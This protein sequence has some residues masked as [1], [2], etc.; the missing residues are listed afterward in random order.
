VL[1]W[2]N[3]PDQHHSKQSKHA[4][5]TRETFK[6]VYDQFAGAIRNYIYYRSG[7]TSLADDITQETFIRIWEKQIT[8]DEKKTRSLLYK[9]ANDFLIDH[10]RKHNIRIEYLSDLKFRLKADLEES[11][12]QEMMR[13]KCEKALSVLTEK[14]RI[15]FLMSKK[16][17]MKYSEIAECLNI[18]KKA[19]EKRM[20]QA[21]KKMKL[22]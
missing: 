7:N 1:I 3:F 17:E 15:V 9:I 5:L 16:D 6:Y 8:Y 12:D 13:Q 10:V 18:S 22:K 21:L 19:V 14:E 4:A 2:E 20:S 11:K